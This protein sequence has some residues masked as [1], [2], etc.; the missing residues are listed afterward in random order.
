M[1]KRTSL[2]SEIEELEKKIEYLANL[3]S[4]KK[5]EGLEW[6]RRAYEAKFSFENDT[7]KQTTLKT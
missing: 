4:G 3:C 7:E 1:E 2:K 6:E 5:E